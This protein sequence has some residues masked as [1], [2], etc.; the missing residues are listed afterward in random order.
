MKRSGRPA[1]KSTATVAT[2]SPNIHAVLSR[3]ATLPSHPLQSQKSV[4]ARFN[5]VISPTASGNW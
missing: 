4:T 1:A 2:V 5:A 3:K